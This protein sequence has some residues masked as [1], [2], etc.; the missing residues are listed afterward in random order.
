MAARTKR[1]MHDDNTRKKIQASQ[2]INRLQDHILGKNELSTTQVRA[3]QVLL[4]K[5]LPDLSAVEM[6]ADVKTQNI[7]SAEPLSDDE[8]KN[9]YSSNLEAAAGATESTH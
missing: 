1:I 9:R 2:I 8:W 5:I 6:V 7:V 4:N 3:A